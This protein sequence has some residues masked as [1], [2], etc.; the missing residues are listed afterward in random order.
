[1][2]AGKRFNLICVFILSMLVVA[3]ARAQAPTVPSDV[4]AIEDKV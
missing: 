4:K 2:M 3:G 1:V